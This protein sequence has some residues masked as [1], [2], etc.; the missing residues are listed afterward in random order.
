MI[1][2]RPKLSLLESLYVP[3]LVTGLSITFKHLA[4]TLGAI[5]LRNKI[6]HPRTLMDFS[7]RAM[8]TMQYPEEKW[9]MPEGYRGA[10]TLV[11]DE[12]GREKCVSCQLCEFVCPPRAIRVVPGEIASRRFANVEKAPQEFFIDM[13]RCIY[14]GFCEE[15]CPEEAIF[16]NK[17]YHILADYSR[18]SLLHNKRK[19]YEMGGVVRRPIKKWAN[20]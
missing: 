11:K 15:A 17:D 8:V 13:V 9:P 19:L 12:D 14:C 4:K 3:A 20:K 18:S 16:L 5:I 7:Q 10:P 6:K 2:R 1:V